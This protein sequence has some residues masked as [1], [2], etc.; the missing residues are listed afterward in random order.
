MSTYKIT[1]NDQYELELA[2][3]DLIEIVSVNDHERYVAFANKSFST[4]VLETDFPSK[5]VTLKINGNIYRAK[6]EDEYDELI[7]KLGYH[8][9]SEDVISEIKAP[10]PGLVLDI[11]VEEGQEVTKGEKL[12]ILEAMKMENVITSPGSGTVSKIVVAKG[13]A[14]EKDQ[15]LIKF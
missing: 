7:K 6:I 2:Q 13:D 11:A 14:V 3:Q 4:Q 12:I 5:S 8:S 10:M 9:K 1:I 15:L